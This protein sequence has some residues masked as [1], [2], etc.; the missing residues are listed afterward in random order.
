MD[1]AIISKGVP[2]PLPGSVTFFLQKKKVTKE[3]LSLTRRAALV[4]QNSP[5]LLQ[6]IRLIQNPALRSEINLP[7]A[8]FD[9]CRFTQLFLFQFSH[10]FNDRL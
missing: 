8:N 3:K 9:F 4:A 2:R 5:N 6:R 10:V 7:S 1:H